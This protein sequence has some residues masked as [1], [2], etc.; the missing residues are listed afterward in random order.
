MVGAGWVER[1]AMVV[2]GSTEMVGF[3]G[4]SATVG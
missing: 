2:V 3:G 1:L 4:G